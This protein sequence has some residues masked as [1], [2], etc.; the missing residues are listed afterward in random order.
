MGVTIKNEMNIGTAVFSNHTRVSMMNDATGVERITVIMGDISTSES[1]DT[2]ETI[3]QKSPA[4]IPMRK[5]P[6]ILKTENNTER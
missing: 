3:P 5:P 6:N 4:M 2:D 1:F